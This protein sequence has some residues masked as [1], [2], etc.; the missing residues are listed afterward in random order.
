MSPLSPAVSLETVDPAVV[1]VVPLLL[2]L[3]L[4]LWVRLKKRQRD[5]RAAEVGR[6]A[7]EVARVDPDFS[8]PRLVP[9]AEVLFDEVMQ[10]FA[11]QDAE[12]LRAVTG[13]ELGQ[14]WARRVL[15]GKTRMSWY[16]LRAVQYAGLVNGD[17]DTE[18]WVVM[19]IESEH[20]AM[21]PHHDLMLNGLSTREIRPRF[22]LGRR[23]VGQHGW[24]LAE[25]WALG[26]RDDGWVVLAVERETMP[27]RRD[28]F[29]VVPFLEQVEPDRVPAS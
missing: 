25:H 11:A 27:G 28:R 20:G 24:V 17:D 16:R 22:S 1:L 23:R 5:R 12:R 10:A 26:K 3:G 14:R 21:P 19:R 13:S 29:P 2:A 9:A 6:V 15:D 4:A 7:A 8:P 18:D